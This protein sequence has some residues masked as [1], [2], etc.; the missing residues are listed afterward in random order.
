MVKLSVILQE[1][2]CCKFK[3]IY[4]HKVLTPKTDFGTFVPFHRHAQVNIT[5]LE[6]PPLINCL[7]YVAFICRRALSLLHLSSKHFFF[8]LAIGLDVFD[9]GRCSNSGGHVRSDHHNSLLPFIT[10]T[11][12]VCPYYPPASLLA[13]PA[14]LEHTPLLPVPLGGKHSNDY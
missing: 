7:H 10:P 14:L 4:C 3:S 8:Q 9:V 13:K 12:S 11:L 5:V 1:Q 6:F 2:K